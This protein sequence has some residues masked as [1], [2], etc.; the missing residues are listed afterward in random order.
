MNIDMNG[1]GSEDDEVTAAAIGEYRAGADFMVVHFKDTDTIMH[2]HG[3]YTPE[4]RA[5]VKT[6]DAEIGKILESLDNGTVVVIYADHGC[7]TARRGGNHGTLI[8]DDMY[9]PL[10]VGRV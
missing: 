6:A 10:I 8:P 4:G 7:H 1:D 3:P 5:S 9:I 2:D